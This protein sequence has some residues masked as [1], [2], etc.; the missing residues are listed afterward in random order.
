MSAEPINLF[1]FKKLIR[2]LP[3]PEGAAKFLSLGTAPLRDGGVQIPGAHG[4]I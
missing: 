3:H 1:P 4:S 2:E